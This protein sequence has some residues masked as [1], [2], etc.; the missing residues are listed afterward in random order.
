MKYDENDQ[1]KENEKG[2]PC[3]THQGKGNAYRI[4]KAKVVPVLNEISTTP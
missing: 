4:K 2:R 1:V 3:S